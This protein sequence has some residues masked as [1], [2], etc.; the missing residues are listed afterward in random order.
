MYRTNSF[1]K[2]PFNR[3]PRFARGGRFSRRGPS[4]DARID[5]SRFINTNVAPKKVEQYVPEHKFSDFNVNQRIK[6]NIA[7]KGYMVPTP[8][9]DKAIPH[10][11]QGLDLVGIANTGTG[12]TGAFIIPLI[13]KVILSNC[14]ENVLIIAPTRE[15]AI[16]IDEEF[17]GFSRGLNLF[18]V[19][20]V[21]GV[22]IGRQIQG[23]RH[24]HNF[25][26]GTPG[27]IKDL[28]QRRLINLPRFGS[29]VLDEADRM[30]DMGFIDDM[31]FI[32]SSLPKNRQ[33]LLFSAT[34]SD[35]V[36]RLIGEFTKNPIKVSVKTPGAAEGIHQDVVRIQKG[37]S[38]I[39]ILHNLLI[40]PEFCKVL[41]FGRTKM[42]VER[43]SRDLSLRG[44]KADSIHGDK[45]QSRRQ[46][47]LSS[48][49]GGRTQI[50]IATDVAARGLDINGVS[51]VINYDLPATYSDY[52]H[53]IGRTGR[54]GK[55]GYAL[56]FVES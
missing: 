30:L 41:I 39:E 5:I 56:T 7:D 36:E 3:N 31:R 55:E 34:M 1:K 20:C 28:V 51:H 24:Y 46:R 12:K 23:L 50:L 22:S 14:K 13:N 4:R 16:Q 25:I 8:I 44:F 54:A 35:E 29:F 47:A 33:T 32:A 42:G 43:L 49:K 11:L 2:R 18:S 26:I 19:C 27:R 21:G 6:N 9:Q 40:K 10:L 48:F 38:K 15:L 37:L 53:R 45:N 17:K 52:I